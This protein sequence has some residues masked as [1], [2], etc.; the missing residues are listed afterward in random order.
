MIYYLI[1][2]LSDRRKY[3]KKSIT[4]ND[5][6]KTKATWRKLQKTKCKKF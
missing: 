2:S 3:V 6:I 1:V 5:L 4:L